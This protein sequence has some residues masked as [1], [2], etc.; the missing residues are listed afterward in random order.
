M[1]L[2]SLVKIQDQELDADSGFAQWVMTRMSG[3]SL[4]VELIVYELLIYI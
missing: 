2:L 1:W 4:K 3:A